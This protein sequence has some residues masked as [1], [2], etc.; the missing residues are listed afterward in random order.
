MSAEDKKAWD[1][2]RT[3][4]DAER[5]EFFD[6]LKTEIGYSAEGFDD[7]AKAVFEDDLLEWARKNYEVC[8]TDALSIACRE[9]RELKTK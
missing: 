8:K 6:K 2:K 5:T 4:S 3:A 1:E 9:G 7:A